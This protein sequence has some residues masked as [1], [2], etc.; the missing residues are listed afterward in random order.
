MNTEKYQEHLKKEIYEIDH[1]NGC[2][3]KDDGLQNLM[4]QVKKISRIKLRNGLR[5]KYG[6]RNYR[7]DRND[8][9]HIYGVMPNSQSVGWWLMGDI[10]EAE[11]WLGFH[12]R[13]V[14][15]SEGDYWVPEI[16]QLNKLSSTH[17]KDLA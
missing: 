5:T 3:M 4:V 1:I 11:L 13:I 8:L 6:K 2:H 9:V 12:D 17:G 14:N 15:G 10:I 16:S 7:I